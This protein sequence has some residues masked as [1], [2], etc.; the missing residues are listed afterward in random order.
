L[1]CLGNVLKKLMALRLGSMVETYDL[2]HPDQRGGCPQRSTIN[3]AMA[4]THDV[5]MGYSKC[6]IMTALFLNV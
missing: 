2:L 5:K 3:A 4:L 6:L 1:N